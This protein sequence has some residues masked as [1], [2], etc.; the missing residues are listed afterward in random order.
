MNF[1]DI[2]VWAMGRSG[3]HPIIHW[4]LDHSGGSWQYF[5]NAFGDEYS[6]QRRMSYS[7]HST[8]HVE[9]LVTSVE[10]PADWPDEVG[11][12]Q[13]RVPEHGDKVKNIVMVR[14][15]FNWAAS[16]L[17]MKG[18]NGRLSERT[19]N[20]YLELCEE[21]ISTAYLPIDT[22]QISYNRWVMSHAY[23]AQIGEYLG[24][25]PDCFKPYVK[26]TR[27]G[28]GSSFDAFNY[29]DTADSMKVFDRWRTYIGHPIMH[30][31]ANNKKLV[32]LAIRAF[33]DPHPDICEWVEEIRSI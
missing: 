2:R 6:M 22:L 1:D 4:I 33:R 28:G 32:D 12:I 16:W 21:Y 7:L 18:N 29:A 25:T 3:H 27:E 30:K 20:I 10:T 8:K 23:R 13:K 11:L 9:L 24:L 14:D 15:P 26:V 19:I 17:N 5:N 31:L